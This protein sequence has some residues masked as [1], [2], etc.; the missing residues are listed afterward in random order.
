VLRAA[1][2][3]AVTLALFGEAHAIDRAC[4]TGQAWSPNLGACVARQATP[5]ASPAARYYEASAGLDSGRADD[6]A[7]ARRTLAATCA[8]RHAASCTLLGFV[9]ERGR[10]GAADPAAAV[11]RYQRGCDLGDVDGCLAAAA[12]WALGLVGDPAPTKAIAPLERACALGSGRGCYA[13]AG[14]YD[15]ALGVGHDAARAR[16]LY[17]RAVARLTAE[18]PGSGPACYDLGVA[19]R[20]GRGHRR[21]RGRRG[22]GLRCRLRGRRRRRLLGPRRAVPRRAA[23]PQP[24]RPRPG[25]LRAELRA[26]R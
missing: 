22:P 15:G 2:I 14:K 12:V 17:R 8:A 1:A 11:E 23:R 24:A 9:L 18:C 21:R 6:I 10:G 5:K 16:D 13:L 25:L 7:R 3:V 20:D 4:P 26:L 19:Q